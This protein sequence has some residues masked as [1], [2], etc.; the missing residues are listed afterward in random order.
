MYLTEQKASEHVASLT[1]EQA[2]QGLVKALRSA[3]YNLN[4]DNIGEIT[5]LINEDLENMA[6]DG[7]L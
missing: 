7:D 1:E 3:S 5:N 4:E 2:R 6:K